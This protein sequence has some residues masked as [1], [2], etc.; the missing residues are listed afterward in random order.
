MH[1]DGDVIRSDSPKA[2]GR[3]YQPCTSSGKLYKAHED[4]LAD[5][6]Y[7]RY[8]DNDH[9]ESDMG[10][11]LGHHSSPNQQSLSQLLS[12]ATQTGQLHKK[13]DEVELSQPTPSFSRGLDPS[14]GEVS[15]PPDG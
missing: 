6:M 15:A 9:L 10:I 11:N 14:L 13:A 4:N 12:N 8:W 3:R 5:Y 1:G 2:D 7:G